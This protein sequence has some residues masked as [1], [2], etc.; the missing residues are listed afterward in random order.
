MENYVIRTKLADN[1]SVVFYYKGTDKDGDDSIALN[2]IVAF[3]MEEA[4]VLD[5]ENAIRL[6]SRLNSEKEAL[7]AKGYLEFKIVIKH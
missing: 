7:L 6:C 2:T 5:K 1:P 3:S 4:E